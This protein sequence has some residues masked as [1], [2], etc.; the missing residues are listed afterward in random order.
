[1]GDQIMINLRKSLLCVLLLGW[2]ASVANAQV[3]NLFGPATGVLKGATSTYQTSAAAS[4]DIAGLWIDGSC[5]GTV[6]LL[7]NGHCQAIGSGTGTGFTTIA[8]KPADTSRAST[9]TFSAD[10]DLTFSNVAAGS[11]SFECNL[12]WFFS[13]GS[14]GGF[15]EGINQTGGTVTVS[16]FSFIADSDGNAS[17]LQSNSAL[18]GPISSGGVGVYPTAQIGAGAAHVINTISGSIVLSVTAT[19]LFVNWTQTASSAVNTTLKQ[20]SWCRLLKTA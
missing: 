11:Y 5:V 1:M 7:L 12:H 2:A 19:T 3:Y 4:A 9:T 15:Q 16:E 20:G 18:V 14:N 6:A 10:P 8:V 13:A 17:Q